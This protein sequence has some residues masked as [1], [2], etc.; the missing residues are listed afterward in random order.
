MNEIEKS[1]SD[2]GPAVWTEN[3][4]IYDLSDNRLTSL[5]GCPAFMET[6][7]RAS[8]NYLVDLMGA[9]THIGGFLNVS[10]NRITTLLGCPE[11]ID[12]S[13]FC[14]NNPLLSLEYGPRTIGNDLN[15]TRTNISDLRGLPSYIGGNLVL[16]N[17]GLLTSLA[18]INR[19]G[20]TLKGKI[21][22]DGTLISSHILGIFLLIECKGINYSGSG[23]RRT[24]TDIVNRHISKGRSGMLSCQQELIEHGLHEYAQI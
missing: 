17:C 19:Y 13:F 8:Y 4:S 10:D 11:T 23:D 1:V 20:R 14:H 21:H 7:I 6:S 15:L 12:G 22:L 5:E 16:E 9:P 3:R 18:N 2:L 24:V